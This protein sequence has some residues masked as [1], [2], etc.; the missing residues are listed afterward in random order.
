MNEVAFPGSENRAAVPSPGEV[1]GIVLRRTVIRAR[2]ASG[3]A[4]QL[5]ATWPTPGAAASPATGPGGVPS[6][7]VVNVHWLLPGPVSRLPARSRT[8]GS[9]ISYFVPIARVGV[10]SSKAIGPVTSL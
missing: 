9:S 5:S 6:L 1:G 8:A 4:F 3:G 2:S 7:E 10:G